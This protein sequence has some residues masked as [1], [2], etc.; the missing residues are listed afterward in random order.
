MRAKRAKTAALIFLVF[1]A[2]S[3]CKGTYH[4]EADLWHIRKD[5]RKVLADPATAVPSEFAELLGEYR[6]L[7]RKYPSWIES[8]RIQYSIADMYSQ[9]KDYGTAREE[10]SKV[11]QM[12]GA[13]EDIQSRAR[14]EIGVQY[15]K[16]SNWP[17]ALK[18]YEL[19]ASKYGTTAVGL[20]APLIIAQHYKQAGLNGESRK[21]FEAAIATYRK[22]ITSDPAGENVLFCENL[23]VTAYGNQ[24]LWG[25]AV[26]EMKAIAGRHYRTE[27]SAGALYQMSLIYREYLNEPDIAIALCERIVREFPDSRVKRDAQYEIAD[28]LFEH[29]DLAGS[30]VE[31]TRI[32]DK[33]SNNVALCAVAQLGIA[34]GYE[35]EGSW[36]KALFEFNKLNFKYPDSLQSMQSM[37][38]VAK[39]Y[40]DNNELMEAEKAFRRAV[41][42]FDMFIRAFPDRPGAVAA[43]EYIGLAYSLQERWV[44]ALTAFETLRYKYPSSNRSSLAVFRMAE[45]YRLKLKDDK[46]AALLYGQFVRDYPDHE[47]AERARAILKKIN[48]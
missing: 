29:G 47:L 15:E 36:E 43:Q 14:F 46:K 16:E 44:D 24:G 40:R 22:L 19:A 7:I 48:S 11:I 41:D 2:F 45:I 34:V 27:A 23:L 21:Y 25:E 18:Q 4:A 30:R 3:G 5:H 12:P 17:E 39:H 13:G 8:A 20:R 6:K 37:L 32:L 1:A 28:I 9:R 38:M 26:R 10:F 42:K 35:K 31:M 33:Y